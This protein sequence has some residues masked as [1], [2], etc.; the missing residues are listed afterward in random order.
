MDEIKQL[1]FDLI[2]HLFSQSELKQLHSNYYLGNM[3]EA[4]V[5]KLE[6]LI[7]QQY[8]LLN[9]YKDGQEDT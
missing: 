1:D 4:S 6:S 3:S 2:K 5:R 8:N 9:P 7:N